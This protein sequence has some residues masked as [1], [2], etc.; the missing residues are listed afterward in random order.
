MCLLP[1]LYP[2]TFIE[3]WL[4]V[5]EAVIVLGVGW[6]DC[7]S[8]PRRTLHPCLTSLWQEK[9]SRTLH[10]AGLTI[11]CSPPRTG[12]TWFSLPQAH[13]PL[14]ACVEHSRTSNSCPLCSLFIHA[15]ARSYSSSR[16][17]RCLLIILMHRILHHFTHAASWE[18]VS[19]SPTFFP[20]NEPFATFVG[21]VCF[22]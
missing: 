3:E 2:T 6:Q 7:Q 16:R 4:V 19:L 20:V 13:S 10:Y 1:L 9:P 8:S 22:P 18:A 11:V 15:K 21:G 5:V 14:H 17:D 12:F